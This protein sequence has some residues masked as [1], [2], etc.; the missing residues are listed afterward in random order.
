MNLPKQGG[1]ED[2]H[3]PDVSGDKGQKDTSS[4]TEK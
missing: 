3:V 4:C 2:R 1:I